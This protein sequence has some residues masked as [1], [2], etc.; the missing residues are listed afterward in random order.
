MKEPVKQTL[1]T[2]W[3]LVKLMFKTDALR[4]VVY[5]IFVGMRHAIPLIS[6]WLWKLILDQL[7]VIYQTKTSSYSV[8]LYLIIFLLLQ[9]FSSIL[10]Q[11]NSVIY[12]KI[13]RKASL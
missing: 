1:Q 10:V 4:G 3:F 12:Q 6:V 5:W 9:V 11:V 8:W 2:E 13:K 7:T